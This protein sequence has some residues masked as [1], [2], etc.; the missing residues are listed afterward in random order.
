M[1]LLLFMIAFSIAWDACVLKREN[2]KDTFESLKRGYNIQETRSI[3]L[4]AIL[5]L[6]AI[7][8]L[9]QQVASGSAAEFIKSALASAAAFLGG[10]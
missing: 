2:L 7:I 5:V 9:G 8:A 6:V 10:G 4:Y 1:Q 3:V